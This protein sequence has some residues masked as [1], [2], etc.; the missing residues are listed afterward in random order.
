M[1]HHAG[2]VLSFSMRRRALKHVRSASV[3]STIAT[4]THGGASR[5]SPARRDDRHHACDTALQRQLP[6]ATS[7][8]RWRD[9]SPGVVK[10]QPGAAHVPP[11]SFTHELVV[12]RPD[13][14]SSRASSCANR[15]SSRPTRRSSG[16]PGTRRAQSYRATTRP[17]RSLRSAVTRPTRAC[18]RVF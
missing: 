11:H 7:A 8:S 3:F 10:D 17:A 14:T 16:L 2:R 15:R 9:P 18:F 13:S 12:P 4:R 5:R 6:S 1:P